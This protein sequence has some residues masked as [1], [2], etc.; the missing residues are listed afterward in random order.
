MLSQ[1]SIF[2]HPSC[3]DEHGCVGWS[4]S[5][6]LTTQTLLDAYSHGIFPWPMGE[7]APIPWVSPPKRA[8]LF[9]KNLHIGRSTKRHIK[10]SMFTFKVNYNFIDVIKGCASVKRPDEPDTW[11]TSKMIEAY[12]KLHKLGYAWSFETYNKSNQLVGGVYGVKLKHYFCAESMFHLESYASKFALLQGID[13]L[14]QHN[15]NWLDHQTKSDH[16]TA[17]G[18]IELPR[19][20]FLELLEKTIS[21]KN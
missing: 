20:N 7:D 16:L 15:I 18:S 4:E 5:D 12:T 2:P 19:D 11:I 21:T 17:L 6:M 10:K 14:K 8:I 9:F 1:K 3:S 13:Y